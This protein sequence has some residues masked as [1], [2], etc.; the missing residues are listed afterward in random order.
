[1]A[2]SSILAVVIG[3]AAVCAGCDFGVVCTLEA[4]PGIRAVIRDSVSGAGLAAS[5]LAVARAGVFVDTLRGADSVAY[6]LSERAGIYRLE[7]SRSGY[8]PWALDGV[9]VRDGECHVETV[10]VTALLVPN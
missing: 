4:R 6:G 10:H 9:W 7:V 3:F 8:Q 1:M 5:A 2:R